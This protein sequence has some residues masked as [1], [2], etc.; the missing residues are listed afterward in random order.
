MQE[1]ETNTG[2]W[3]ERP[4]REDRPSSY[5]PLGGTFHARRDGQRHLGQITPGDCAHGLVWLG[6]RPTGGLLTG[7][8]TISLSE[9]IMSAA[10]SM[11]E[12]APDRAP[13]HPRPRL[14]A[15]CSSCG[16]RNRAA[17]KFCIGCVGPL[18]GAPAR[19]QAL[20]APEPTYIATIACARVEAPGERDRRW[21]TACRG[22]RCRREQR[23][24][25]SR[26]FACWARA[27][28]GSSIWPGT[29]CWSAMWRSRNTCRRRLRSVT[30]TRWASR[31][32]RS[33]IAA[34]SMRGSG[35]F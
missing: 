14:E 34:P 30:R 6:D 26:S 5:A 1:H 22:M 20:A 4:E 17:A 19:A 21:T 3:A 9:Q 24:R 16:A 15:I 35:A 10:S 27:A 13:A 33:A 25:A 11:P 18:A 23:S 31:C 7:A 32:A 8:A 29:P 12:P 2:W 28:S